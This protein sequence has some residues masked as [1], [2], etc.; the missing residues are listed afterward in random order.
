MN[1]LT[2][3][4]YEFIFYALKKFIVSSGFLSNICYD[5]NG[6][7]QMVAM[8][9]NGKQSLRGVPWNK[10]KSENTE[11]LYLLGAMKEPVQIDYKKACYYVISMDIIILQT[12]LLKISLIRFMVLVS[13]YSMQWVRSHLFNPYSPNVTFLYPLKTS[14]NSRIS[15]VFRGY[16][17]VTL[18]EC[19][20]IFSYLFCYFYK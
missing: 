15:D 20:L 1:T 12:H 2:H 7:F 10:L 8:N 16:R 4:F 9:I 11:T 6:F 19:G 13:L 18:G 3:C 14:E 17:N 5:K